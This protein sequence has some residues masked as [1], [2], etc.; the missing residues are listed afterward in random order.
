MGF[1]QSLAEKVLPCSWIKEV[2]GLFLLFKEHLDHFPKND[3]LKRTG[4][5]TLRW[6]I[7]ETRK[8]FDEIIV[9]L[10]PVLKKLKN[11]HQPALS[12][13]SWPRFRD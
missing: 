6:L 12:E 8:A 7:S 13:N 4:P 9:P 2:L 3:D 1:L 5:D 10:R 11:M